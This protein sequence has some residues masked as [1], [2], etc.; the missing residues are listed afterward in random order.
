MAFRHQLSHEY[1]TVNP[2]AVWNLAQ[3]ALPGRPT[4][5]QHLLED[6][7]WSVMFYL[8]LFRALDHHRV[9]YALI[10]GLAV[11][12][13][14]VERNTM[15]IDISVVMSPENLQHLIAAAR[16]LELTPMLP[17]PLETLAD[18]DTLKQW[19]SQRNLQAFA[20]RSNALAG[21]TLDVLLFP[22]V[23]AGALCERA[24]RLDVTGV[25]V[26]LASVQDLIALKAAVGRPIDLADIEHL[27]RLPSA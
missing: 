6:L 11:A 4:G 21:V 22:P 5:V 12:L 17:V 16:A 20:L 2:G 15:D 13:H 25:P 18:L 24:L 19:H 8:D 1:A 7:K 23:D 27:K 14:G 26:R 9:K 3:D 10:G